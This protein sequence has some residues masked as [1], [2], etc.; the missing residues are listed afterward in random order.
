ME[1]QLTKIYSKTNLEGKSTNLK[2]K[3]EDRGLFKRKRKRNGKRKGKRKGN[4]K[5]ND[6]WVVPES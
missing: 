2:D 6:K 3:D 1:M 4:G 5:R